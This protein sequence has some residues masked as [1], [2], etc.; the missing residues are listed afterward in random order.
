[1][2]SLENMELVWRF[3]LDGNQR[4]DPFFELPSSASPS[5]NPLLEQTIGWL[6]CQVET[7][8]DVGDRTVYVA[9]VVEG[10]VINFAPP[11]TTGK[12]MELAPS[13]R[14][15]QLQRARHH[16]CYNEAQALRAWRESHVG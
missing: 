13:S 11:L 10:R 4:I 8:L 16:Q 3:G 14:L 6:D 1:M 15:V 12:L 5:G 7:S 9:E 2:L